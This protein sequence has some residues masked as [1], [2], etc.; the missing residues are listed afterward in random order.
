M[1][2]WRLALVPLEPPEAMVVATEIPVVALAVD[3]LFVPAVIKPPPPADSPPPASLKTNKP[4]EG[5]CVCPES[6][7]VD[8]AV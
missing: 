6:V 7:T 2:G 8:V 5:P 4:A 1:Y 3:E